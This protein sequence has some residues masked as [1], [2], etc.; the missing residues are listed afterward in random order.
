MSRYFLSFFEFAKYMQN[1]LQSAYY[2]GTFY[3]IYSYHSN[4]S[5]FC[6]LACFTILILLLFL[7]TGCIATFITAHIILSL[8]LMLGSLISLTDNC[9]LIKCISEQNFE[10]YNSDII[11]NLIESRD[12]NKCC[13]CNT[14]TNLYN[15][16]NVILTNDIIC[17]SDGYIEYVDT[18]I[19]F[20]YLSLIYTI[21]FIAIVISF[22]TIII[23]FVI[24]TK[25]TFAFVG[26][27][28]FEYFKKLDSCKNYAEKSQYDKINIKDSNI[29][30]P[31]DIEICSQQYHRLDAISI[32]N[33][34]IETKSSSESESDSDS[35]SISVK[36][37]KT[38]DDGILINFSDIEKC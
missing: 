28:C 32:E 26:L 35:S 11:L 3:P 30:N 21:C 18:G 25:K 37:Y 17:K 6:K 36:S 2:V 7:I 22:A 12:V 29:I 38:S 4:C 5:I 19:Y 15:Y 13:T 16:P 14:L 27:Q 34:L 8:V 24:L 23:C 20:I 1:K 31:D 33:K 9:N 10:K